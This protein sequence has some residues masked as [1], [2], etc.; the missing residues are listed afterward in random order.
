M[1]TIFKGIFTSHMYNNVQCCVHIT[2][3]RAGSCRV[4]MSGEEKNRLG[5]YVQNRKRADDAGGMEA[6]RM[7]K[8][9]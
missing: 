9:T 7:A 6:G 1:N 8:E 5:I 4:H 3:I 2:S